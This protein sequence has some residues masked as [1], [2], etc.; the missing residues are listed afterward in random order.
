METHETRK[1][2][3]LPSKWS[4]RFFNSS[5]NVEFEAFS[6]NAFSNKLKFSLKKKIS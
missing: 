2:E 3:D 1:K 4:R 5:F 6:K